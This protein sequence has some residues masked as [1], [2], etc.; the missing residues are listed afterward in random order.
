[1]ADKEP[2]LQRLVHRLAGCPADFLA[3]PQVHGS[4]GVHVQAVIADLLR[5]IAGDRTVAVTPL[6]HPTDPGRPNELRIALIASWLLFD[7]WFHGRPELTKRV[8]ALLFEGLRPYARLVEPDAFVTDPDRREELVRHCLSALGRR[9]A[10]E[11]EAQAADRLSALDS[12]ARDRVL[13]DTRAAHER[14]QQVREALK[15]KAAQE[16]AAKVSRE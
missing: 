15:R 16:A 12:I 13:R 7:N 1:M 2:D 10:G 9:P 8:R 11:T 5:H 4:G 14:A 6:L 3:Q